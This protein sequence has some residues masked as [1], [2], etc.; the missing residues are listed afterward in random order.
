ME[1]RMSPTL[2]LALSLLPLTAIAC[3][4][5]TGVSSDARPG[6]GGDGAPGSVDASSS[7]ADARVGPDAMP[8]QSMSFFITSTGSGAGGG[9]LGG[10]AGADAKCQNLAINGGGG[11][12]TWHAYLSTG[13]TGGG[14]IVDARDRIGAGPWRNQE[15]TM[16]AAN[17]A[18][19]HSDGI[20]GNL[21]VDELG[22]VVPGNQHDVLTGTAS[23]GT[24]SD[25]SQTCDNWTNG[26]INSQAQVGHAD[27]VPDDGRSWNSE[28]S[29]SCDEASLIANA[30]AG[31]LYCFA[32]D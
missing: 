6:Q 19:L 17:V 15:G 22:G 29:G 16:V 25:A 3:S 8:N 12:R 21:I 28:H 13:S 5:S 24:L 23:D 7:P 30:G 32:I 11:A 2:H 9:N 10:L 1:I 4:D 31:R 18:A 14:P 26:T 20:L 27:T